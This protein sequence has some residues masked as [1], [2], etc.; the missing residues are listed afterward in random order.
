MAIEC[1]YYNSRAGDRKYNA[2]TMSKYFVGLM[3][4][5][6]SEIYKDKLAVNS[7]GGLDIVVETGKC[8]FPS[9]RWC[10]NTSKLELSCEPAHVILDRIDRVIVRSDKS[11]DVRSCEI[12]VRSGTPAENPVPP[13][14]VLD[15]YVEELSLAQI[16][17]AKRVEAITQSEIIDERPDASCCGFVYAL[18][19]K[20]DVEDLY[21]QHQS[22]F[23]DFMGA[24]AE[25]MDEI[26]ANE[27]AR[28]IAESDRAIT[29][30]TRSQV[31]A[32]SIRN[33]DDATT[34]AHDAADAVDGQVARAVTV[35][36]EARDIAA[37]VRHDADSGRFNGENGAPGVVTSLEP[38]IFCLSVRDGH[39]IL[40]H[41]ENEPDPPLQLKEDGHLVYMIG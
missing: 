4:K 2:E 8:F 20:V 18:G 15:D 10:E 34:R 16:R 1:G 27:A 17:V 5:G 31:F 19:Q 21:R 38:G 33:A 11:E 41:N 3:S 29:E 28:V 36:S 23:D 30:T 32:E 26:E 7:A 14:L 35:S 9:G 24:N 37:S 39:L 13:D 22:I 12:L 40:T 25:T 6:V